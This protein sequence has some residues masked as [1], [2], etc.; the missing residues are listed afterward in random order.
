MGKG[1]LERNRQT[2]VS[3]EAPG[4]KLGGQGT[5]GRK[6][7]FEEVVPIGETRGVHSRGGRRTQTLQ[8]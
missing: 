5:E 2:G 8:W 1:V 4:R 3:D 7:P 6:L